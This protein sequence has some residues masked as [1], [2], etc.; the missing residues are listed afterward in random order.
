M[1]AADPVF[2]VDSDP[3]WPAAFQAVGRELR[4][5]LG[6][7]AHRIDHI[8]STAVP[9]LAAKPVIDVQVSVAAL[10]PEEP[11][12]RALADA[13]YVW[14]RE[15]PDLT[16]RLFREQPRRAR[17]HVHV[18]A[19]GSFAEQSALLFR[20]YLRADEGAAAE[21]ARVKRQLAVQ[22]RDDRD[23]Y[24]EAKAATVW[25]TLRRA[26]AWAQATGWSPAPSDS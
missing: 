25:Q 13:G 10:A 19:A 26:A 24:C 8:G 6:H 11:Y 14:V 9:G 17:V 5:A 15:N 2:I 22:F 1:T 3:A 21:Y 18:R 20:D 16:K 4:A 12:V 23:G 7:A